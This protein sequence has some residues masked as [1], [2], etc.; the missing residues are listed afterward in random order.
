VA[1]G[2]LR[3]IQLP[4]GEHRVVM[5][6]E[7]ASYARGEAASRACSILLILLVLGSVAYS[8]VRKK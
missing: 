7:P 4:A 1:G 6:F 5:S 3:C 8:L 2:L